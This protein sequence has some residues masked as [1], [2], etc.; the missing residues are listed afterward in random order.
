ML[1]FQR[2]PFRKNDNIIAL[3]KTLVRLPHQ[4]P[5]NAFPSVPHNRRPKPAAHHNTDPGIL[6]R[7]PARNHVEESR[8]D[9]L[10]FPFDSL[11]VLCFFQEYRRAP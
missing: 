2:R 1:E 7:G 10:A 11:E 8:R 6:K 4:F 5:K 3:Q 9:T